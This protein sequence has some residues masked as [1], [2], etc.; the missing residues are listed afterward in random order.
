MVSSSLVAGGLYTVEF[1][2]TDNKALGSSSFRDDGGENNTWVRVR[3]FADYL[4]ILDAE[5]V[6]LRSY[7]RHFPGPAFPAERQTVI[8]QTWEEGDLSALE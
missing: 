8:I 4:V 3:A 5:V 2:N 6:T 7:V 1:H